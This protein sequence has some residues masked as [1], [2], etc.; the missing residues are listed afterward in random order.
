MTIQLGYSR[1][2]VLQDLGLRPEDKNYHAGLWLDKFLSNQPAFESQG[3]AGASGALTRLV[4]EVSNM[5]EPTAYRLFFNRWL[6]VLA[7]IGV[8]PR[9]VKINS[10]LAVGLGRDS[11]I[12]TGVTLQHTYG[13]PILPG[14]GLK[15]LAASYAHQHL[16]DTV[17]RK[18]SPAHITLFG[19]QETSGCVTFFDAL[20]VPGQSNLLPDVIA[21]HHPAYYRGEKKP[22]AD[23]DSPIPIPFLTVTGTFLIAL[24]PSPESIGWEEVAYGILQMSL[25]EMGA[26]AKTSSGYGRMRLDGNAIPKLEKNTLLRAA[27]TRVDVGDVELELRDELIMGRPVAGK[28]VYIYIPHDQAGNRQF[29]PGQN[30]YCV[31]LEIL[32]DEYDFIVKCRPAT[33]K[34][35]EK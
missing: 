22:P 26:G 9:L 23:W 17:W 13:V 5:A 11:V 4:N 6:A 24:Q 8:R 33:K 29:R 20:P 14:S 10:R 18:G 12:E 28:N 27:V 16:A 21:V 34:E 31:V 15:G 32:E 2:K 25:A 1:R 30:V 19:S 3:D 35:R 7:Q